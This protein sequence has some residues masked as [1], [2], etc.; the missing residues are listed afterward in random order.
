MCDHR[1][2]LGICSST[3]GLQNTQKLVFCDGTDKQTSRQT[4]T[5]TWQLY[6]WP[7]PE[8]QVIEN[9]PLECQMVT[10]TGLKPTYL[11][12]YLCDSSDSSDRCDSNDSSDRSD[13]CDNNKKFHQLNFL[14]TH[15]IFSKKIS[16]KNFTKK[17][18]YQNLFLTRLF[19]FQ[20]TFSINFFFIKKYLRW[21]IW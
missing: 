18:S 15:F 1:P 19:F 16:T 21:I 9:W 10:K 11:P 4:H 7:G 3:R 13:K 17:A 2:I 14:S 20:K 12:T 5:R 8:G 6:D